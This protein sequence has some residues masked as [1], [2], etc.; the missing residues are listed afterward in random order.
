MAWWIWVLFGFFLAGLELIT[1]SLHFAFFGIGAILV[2]ILVATG[3]A[4]PLWLQ[5][6]LFTIISVVLLL[7]RRRFLILFKYQIPDREMDT[8]TG[9]VAIA[10]DEILP[11]GIG[12][13]ENRGT[14]WNARNAG[15]RALAKG[16]RC[17]VEK[18]EGLT[19][20]LRPADET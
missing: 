7:F 9:E 4:I 11:G 10:I 19:L 13:V 15:N 12:R 17:L 14:S 8:I 16:E 5:L 1:T 3:L 6:F 18:V 20:V 2:G